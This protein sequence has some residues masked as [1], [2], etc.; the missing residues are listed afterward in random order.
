MLSDAGFSGARTVELLS[1]D[2]P[3]GHNGLALIHTTVQ[4]YPHT[5]FAYFRNAAKRFRYKALWNL[6]VQKGRSDW[7]ATA[8][9]LLDH[10]R[11]TGGVFHLWGHS[12]EIEE[13]GQ[14]EALE[15]VLAAMAECKGFARCLT[16]SQLCA[17]GR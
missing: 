11:E 1:L 9:A 17:D 3:Y 7:A 2:R 10:A 16:N 8:I 5:V 13:A 4:A 15:R 12:W 6:F 14:W